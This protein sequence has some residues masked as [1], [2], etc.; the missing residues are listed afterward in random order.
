M[1]LW[2]HF[3]FK[4]Y[5][6]FSFCCVFVCLFENKFSLCS[7]GWPPTH[8]LPA[9]ASRVLGLQECHHF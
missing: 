9:S 5:M 1:G 6:Y 3:R 4:L 7:P 2:R 8:N